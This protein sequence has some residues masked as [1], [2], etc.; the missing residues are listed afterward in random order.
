MTEEEQQKDEYIEAMNEYAEG[1]KKC[2]EAK[3][4]EANI[5]EIPDWN[6]L[7]M[8]KSDPDFKEEF[9][10]VINDETIPEADDLKED[11]PEMFD[12]YINMALALP[13]WDGTEM[14][15][16]RVKWRAL[17]HD[18]T[19]MGS[20]SNNPITDTQLYEVEF[21]DSTT[22]VM[23]ANIIAQNILSK[24]NEEGH[25][26][27]MMEEII[28]H[29][30]N[31]EAICKKD[32]FYITQNG[33]K[34]CKHT[35]KG[36]EVCVQWKDGSFN[37]VALKDI[38]NTYPIE[39]AEYAIANQIQVKSAFAWWVPYMMWKRKAIL[40]KVKSK[41]WQCTHKYGVLIPK[42]VKQAYE[43]D[44]ENGD[45]V[46]RDA[47]NKEMPKIVNALAV[48]DGDPSKLIGYQ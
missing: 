44:E 41:Y 25:W 1:L 9:N 21:I 47:I 39:L 2:L 8:D 10:K 18:S 6:R 11:T 13:Q 19:P 7:S 38:K 36:W 43:I 34:Q 15:H 27:L 42:S 28:D 5:T 35:T 31:N 40:K 30:S 3:D 20:K 17:D 33:L 4:I 45:T 22:E 37:W 14:L 24:V 46:W 32:A 16:A 48:H 12:Q 26:Q 23:A 29:C